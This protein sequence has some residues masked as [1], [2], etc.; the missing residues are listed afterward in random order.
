ML[1]MAKPKHII[2]KIL[3]YYYTQILDSAAAAAHSNPNRF[4]IRTLIGSY[5]IIYLHIRRRR[6]VTRRFLRVRRFR[7]YDFFRF[8]PPSLLSLSS[9][10]RRL[11]GCESPSTGRE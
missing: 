3:V 2:I 8:V 1:T 10:A 4:M 7:E 9:Y 11:L 5:H 6:C